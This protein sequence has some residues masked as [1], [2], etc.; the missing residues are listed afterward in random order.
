MSCCGVFI[1]S[2]LTA[3]L[4]HNNVSYSTMVDPFYL[5]V[6]YLC[7]VL[8][9]LT[10][11]ICIKPPISGFRI[12]LDLVLEGNYY[13]SFHL[14]DTLLISVVLW[15]CKYTIYPCPMISSSPLTLCSYE[16]YLS[17]MLCGMSVFWIVFQGGKGGHKIAA[18][19][20][21][22]HHSGDTHNWDILIQWWVFLFCRDHWWNFLFTRVVKAVFYSAVDV[23][24][25]LN[26]VFLLKLS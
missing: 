20:S 18:Y 6:K 26:S 17:Q 19:K 8:Q 9:H 23:N 3:L 11:Y 15:T 2:I 10:I 25:I 1:H 13:C 16:L 22:C 12:F 14:H 7:Y 4:L 5:K 21:V 24:N